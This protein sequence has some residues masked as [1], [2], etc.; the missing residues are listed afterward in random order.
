MEWINGP[1]LLEAVVSGILDNWFNLVKVANDLAKIIHAAHML[2]ERVLH[3]D[4]RPPN[5]MLRDY[6]ETQIPEVM[7]M[8]FDLSWHKDALEKSI[9]AKPLGFMAP[10][11]LIGKGET[12]SALVDCFGFGMTLFYMLTKELPVPNQ[13]MHRNWETDLKYKIGQRPCKEWKSLPQRVMRLVYQTTLSKQSERL[14]F[15]RITGELNTLFQLL[16]KDSTNVSGDYY[17]E[18]IAAWTKTMDGYAW[19]I[20]K[21]AA[22]YL[23]GGLRVDLAADLPND[24]IQLQV[25]W[26]QTG[27]ENWKNLPK[28]SSQVAKRAAPALENHSWE[29]AKYDASYGN[30]S[31]SAS[32]YIDRQSFNPKNLA[33]GI[34]AVVATMLPKN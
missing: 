4:I 22:I 3:R 21:N 19:N 7:V 32:Y 23:S 20:D 12:R 31:V 5:V 26:Q 28:T 33:L 8:D 14:D 27:E 17:C 16:N 1:N 11:Q 25:R 30:M 29:K 6:W 24:S 9:M 10:E 18:E 2:P 13:Q 15:S 34:D